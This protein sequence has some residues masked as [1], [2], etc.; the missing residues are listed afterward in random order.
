MGC[1]PVDQVGSSVDFSPFPLMTDTNVQQ[2]LQRLVYP[3][4]EPGRAYCAVCL[5][6]VHT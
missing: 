2:A 1:L 6:G 5:D 3:R 4:I